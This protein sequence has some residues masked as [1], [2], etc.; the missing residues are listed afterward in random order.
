MMPLNRLE[1]TG[2][3]LLAMEA[4]LCTTQMA[5]LP[6]APGGDLWEWLVAALERSAVEAPEEPVDDRVRRWSGERLSTARRA[7]PDGA[8]AERREAAA[9]LGSEAR[10]YPAG[11]PAEATTLRERAGGGTAARNG[12]GA[13]DA[14]AAAWTGSAA[15][16]G[17]AADRPQR[18]RY[19]PDPDERAAG[20]AELNHT[21]AAAAAGGGGPALDPPARAPG[22]TGAKPAAA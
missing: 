6:V 1:R 2:E 3:R 13:R 15:P 21:P 11:E 10:R 22:A 17:Y 20:R 7:R 4:L 18:A 12:R 14:A 16:R 8:S 9:R 19:A 5:N